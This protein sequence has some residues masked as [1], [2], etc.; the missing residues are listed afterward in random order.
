MTASSIPD[1]PAFADALAPLE[2]AALGLQDE[3]S[4]WEIATATYPEKA[5]YQKREWLTDFLL[6]AIKAGRL[7]AY[8]NP[9]GWR[10]WQAKTDLPG[11]IPRFLQNPFPRCERHEPRPRFG[12]NTRDAMLGK[13]AGGF[14]RVASWEGVN[15]LIWRADYLAILATPAARGITAPDWWKAPQGEPATLHQGEP[16]RPEPGAAESRKRKRVD[17]L[18]E[19]IEAA[20]EVLSPDGRLPTP[21]RLFEYLLTQDT[22]GVVIP[23]DS[24]TVFYW[25][26]SNGNKKSADFSTIAKRLDRM[27]QGD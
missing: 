7:A 14:K 23:G 26:A 18:A 20:L 13:L 3:L 24:K 15:S 4:I 5:D 12:P 22:T 16:D 17:S 27:K 8:G 6:Q 10:C 2:R 25:I 19:A 9:D 1:V 11:S 21:A